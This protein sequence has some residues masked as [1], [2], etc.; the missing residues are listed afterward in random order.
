MFSFCR[1]MKLNVEKVTTAQPPLKSYCV[2]RARIAWNLRFCR[3]CAQLGVTETSQAG[4]NPRPVIRVLSTRL[5][6]AQDPLLK[7][8]AYVMYPFTPLQL[9]LQPKTMMMVS[10]RVLVCCL[11]HTSLE[12]LTLYPILCFQPAETSCIVK[13]AM[14]S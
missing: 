9:Q 6:E 14:E 2:L 7:M 4:P 10:V 8:T 13:L 1:G 11:C 12:C 3:I 5:L